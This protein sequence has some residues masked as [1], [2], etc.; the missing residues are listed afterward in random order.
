[1]PLD[2]SLFRDEETLKVLLE[3]QRRRYSDASTIEKVIEA[4]KE[5][6]KLQF[7]SESLKRLVNVCSKAVGERKKKK[8]ADGEDLP[9]PNDIVEDVTNDIVVPEKLDALNVTQ[10]KNLSKTFQDKMVELAAKAE[11][12]GAARDKLVM[13]VGNIVH[14]SVPIHNDEDAG[15]AIVRTFGITEK[16]PQHKLNHV[17]VMLKLRGMDTGK[18]ATGMAGGRAYV[19]RGA[20]VQLQ[21]GLVNYAMQFAMGRG[22]IPFYPPFFMTEEA[23]GEVAQLSQFKDELYK[24][25]GEGD[26]KYLIATSEMPIAAY[27]RGRWFTDMKD[28]IKYAGM[29]SCFRKEVGSHGRDTLG[30]FR[31]HQFDKIEQ[32]IL[33]SPKDDESWKMLDS[34][35]DTSEEFCK[36]LG[37]PYRV[38]NICSGALN[39]AAAKKYDLEGFFPGS[40]AYRELV[41]CSN[42][43]D[44]QARSINCRFGPNQRGTAANAQKD[45]VHMLNGTLC[46]IT[47]TMCAIVENY[48][49]D[50][51]VVVPE[52]L[53]P[54]LMGKEILT[55][56]EGEALPQ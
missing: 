14:E 13:D 56:A 22:Y 4:D 40:S 1:M 26:D 11:E 23:M 33:C 3:S 39:N 31:V 44:Y 45:Y 49:T 18:A 43:T 30:I 41:S 9:L 55:Y 37:L 32:F 34:M 2:I 53:R 25:S 6:R 36:S 54:F 12:A 47:R 38:V 20:L 19:L 29:S 27:H 42:C 16:G 46:A 21:L 51:G 24:V 28:P 17:D 52:V 50:E 35:I 7:T 15:N 8:E 5:W 10:I 48:Q